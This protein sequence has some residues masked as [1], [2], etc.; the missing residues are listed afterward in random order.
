L[1]TFRFARSRSYWP[2]ELRTASRSVSLRADTS[3]SRSTAVSDVFFTPYRERRTCYG[4][5]PV[6][7]LGHTVVTVWF[8][9]IFAAVMTTDH[10]V[11]VTEVLSLLSMSLLH[12][13]FCVPCWHCPLEQLWNFTSLKRVHVSGICMCV[14]GGGGGHHAFLKD[15]NCIGSESEKVVKGEKKPTVLWQSNMYAYTSFINPCLYSRMSEGRL[16]D[17]RFL[18]R[19]RWPYCSGLWRRVNS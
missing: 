5:F 6:C 13:F 15:V 14:C 16:W 1:R 8:D 3:M 10:I 2:S 17:L 7:V 9:V 12:L 18:R 11:T 4:P 19:W